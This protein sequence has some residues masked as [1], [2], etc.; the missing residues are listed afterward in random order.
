MKLTVLFL[1][2]FSLFVTA[3]FLLACS[4]T[5][6]YS[7]KNKYFFYSLY[8]TALIVAR[9]ILNTCLPVA[10]ILFLFVLLVFFLLSRIGK[11][12]I[13]ELIKTVF[14]AI[15]VFFLFV[16]GGYYFNTMDIFQPLLSLH[17]FISNAAFVGVFL[18]LSAVLYFI[19]HRITHFLSSSRSTFSVLNILCFIILV[20]TLTLNMLITYLRKSNRA[21]YPSVLLISLDTL[22]SDHL[23]C[24][25]YDAPTSPFL[26]TFAAEAVLFH[27]AFS[28]S[29]W[30]LP[31]H[32]SLFTSQYPIEHGATVR[33]STQHTSQGRGVMLAELL[34]N[35]FF[36]S[37]AYTG[38]GFLSGYLG[39]KEGFD[40]YSDTPL[41]YRNLFDT[42][43]LQFIEKHASQPFF[44][45]LHTYCIHNYQ[46]SPEI[47][48][49]FDP[50]CSGKHHEWE[51]I[52][53]YIYLFQYAELG[54][55][56]AAEVRHLE[57]VYDASI[58]YMDNQIEELFKYLKKQG[59]YDNLMIII[60]ADHGEE[61]G[62]HQHTSHGQ[63]LYDEMIKV[64]LIIR[65]PHGEYGGTQIEEPV[66]L[67]DV[68]PTILDYM[69]IQNPPGMSGVSLSPYLEG[70]ILK[71]RP[72]FSDLRTD[73]FE[74]SLRTSRYHLIYKTVEKGL[75]GKMGGRFLL[76][77]IIGDP[78]ERYDIAQLDTELTFSLQKDLL[79]WLKQKGSGFAREDSRVDIDNKM[80]NDLKS[81]GY[82][83]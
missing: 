80:E 72:A 34:R 21:D 67:I 17:G 44:L 1:R 55:E 57:K 32:M 20:A 64:P 60:T 27:N 48:N 15:L 10:I 13:S 58:K 30:T 41:D 9:D 5:F 19:R 79:D 45:F 39:F 43:S 54:E 37:A 31:A 62:E 22:R 74:F 75:T 53:S 42:R 23:G 38:G 69:G 70:E 28:Q 83:Q 12:E 77:D 81:L 56:E 29:S 4:I 71:E 40:I 25:G 7:V 82:V 46:T 76:Y 49:Q 47:L 6:I 78:G 14:P 26:D 61:F 63:T 2:I 33:K 59:L 18:I 65:F 66:T 51:D 36:T 35:N 8:Y 52:K 68:M 3:V 73:I 50:D 24:Y 11:R 16:L